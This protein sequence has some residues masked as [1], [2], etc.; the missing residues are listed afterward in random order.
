MICVMNFNDENRR[1]SRNVFSF[2]VQAVVKTGS[3]YGINTK[4][5]G[6][7]VHWLEALG[8]GLA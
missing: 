5:T 7:H 8:M 6:L 1:V 4:I 2:H 3:K